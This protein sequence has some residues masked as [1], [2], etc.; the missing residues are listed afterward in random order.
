[1]R[2]ALFCEVAACARFQDP[3]RV[4]LFRMSTKYQYGQIG[5]RTPDLLQN[6]Q[7]SAPMHRDIEQNKI[8]LLFPDS[9]KGLRSVARFTE[10]RSLKFVR[11]DSSQPVTK[12]RMIVNDQNS[13]GLAR[14]RLRPATLAYAR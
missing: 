8:P 7:A 1:M 14:P 11:Q 12:N 10:N 9:V 4:L 13:H 6:I 2:C 3:H 5:C